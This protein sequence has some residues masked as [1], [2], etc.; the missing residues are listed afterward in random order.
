MTASPPVHASLVCRRGRGILI[1]G[2]SGAGK[3]TLAH[4]LIHRGAILVADDYVLLS[5]SGHGVLGHPAQGLAGL[6]EVRGVGLARFPYRR[7]CR[8]DLVVDLQEAQPDRLPEVAY[9]QLADQYVPLVT[10]GEG[11][12]RAINVELALRLTRGG[13]HWQ[14]G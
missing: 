8:I 9:A 12:Q 14:N 6:L 4:Q 7:S 1:R 2:A 5:S 11:V 13:L 3:S 10:L